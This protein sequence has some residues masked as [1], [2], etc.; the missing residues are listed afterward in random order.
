MRLNAHRVL[1]VDDHHLFRDGLRPLFSHESDFT[2]IAEAENGT[3]AI[4]SAAKEQPDL[5]LLDITLKN[6]EN[7]LDF[8]PRLRAVSP[9]S[10][11]VILTVHDDSPS[12]LRAMSTEADGYLHKSARAQEFFDYLRAVASGHQVLPDQ[13]VRVLIQ[14]FRQKWGGEPPE[15]LLTPREAQIFEPLSQ[16]LTNR[17]IADRLQL[18]EHTVRNHVR[19]I[20]LK[21]QARNR[22]EAVALGRARGWFS[23][24][25]SRSQR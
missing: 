11:I 3:E 13:V 5:I 22:R 17:E 24:Q 20:L 6:E 9:L 25:Q 14:A 12:V 18:S 16:R 2:L 23:R 10:R 8:L 7:G 15:V 19:R 4:A 21:L 1:L